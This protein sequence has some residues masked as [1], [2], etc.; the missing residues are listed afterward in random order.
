M[1]NKNT[2]HAFPTVNYKETIQAF[3]I[4][5]DKDTLQAYRHSPFIQSIP[6]GHNSNL[7][8]NGFYS[9][10][11]AM[12]IV[13]EKKNDKQNM[14]IIKKEKTKMNCNAKLQWKL[15]CSS[16]CWNCV[17]RPTTTCIMMSKSLF[18]LKPICYFTV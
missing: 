8:V 17:T 13:V 5:N 12:I 6:W 11:V 3:Q 1:Y 16:I 7:L 18:Y 4:M 10:T 14:K 2:I 9:V 15:N